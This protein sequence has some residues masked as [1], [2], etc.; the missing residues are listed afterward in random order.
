ME[1]PADPIAPHVTFD[2]Y[3]IPQS[4]HRETRT[5]VPPQAQ[6]QQQLR[7]SGMMW[8]V[9]AIALLAFVLGV[10]GTLKFARPT[11]PEMTASVKDTQSSVTRQQSPDLISTS[12]SAQGGIAF[13]PAA[14]LL[15]QDG[16]N[17]T[18]LAAQSLID[19][20]KMRLLREA[21]LAGDYNLTKQGDDGTHRLVPIAAQAEEALI[22]TYIALR[23]AVETGAL[24]LP[25]WLNKANGDVDLDMALFDFIQFSLIN[26]GTAEGSNAAGE[27]NRRVFAASDAKTRFKNGERIYAVQGGDSLAY[28]ALQFYGHPNLHEWI[29]EANRNLLRTAN[30]IRTGQQLIIPE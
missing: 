16:M 2:N 9:S 15:A 26:E 8:A 27:M 1:K 29:F 21:V 7:V 5:Q 4:V 14:A 11:T 13:T 23:S 6:G 24:D 30:G 18:R 28:L 25:A 17:E 22:S 19:A 10:M 12:A 20:D 3:V